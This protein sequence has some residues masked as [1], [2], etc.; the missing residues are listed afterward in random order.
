MQSLCRSQSQRLLAGLPMMQGI[1]TSSTMDESIARAEQNQRRR[2]P[3]QRLEK[4][5]RFAETEATT[6][7]IE[8]IMDMGKEAVDA[9]FFTPEMLQSFQTKAEKVAC[10]VF[11]K[12]K[13]KM[14]GKCYSFD[15]WEAYCACH[16]EKPVPEKIE[17]RLR[18]WVQKKGVR[19]GLERWSVP[20]LEATL[21]KVQKQALR[22]VLKMQ[23]S[24]RDP[25]IIAQIYGQLSRSDAQ[26]GV[27]MAKADEAVV[28]DDNGLGDQWPK[29]PTNQVDLTGRFSNQ[30]ETD[31]QDKKDID[32]HRT[33]MQPESTSTRKSSSISPTTRRPKL[34]KSNSV[35][36]SPTK[37][38]TS[39]PSSSPKSR[40]RLVRSSSAR[41]STKSLNN[42]ME[43][44]MFA[45]SLQEGDSTGST[46]PSG[47]GDPVS[48]RS[49]KLMVQ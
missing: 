11:A 27:L 24:R 14:D 44:V 43:Q 37:S 3:R 42:T 45:M 38:L 26:F 32:A 29:K 36:L 34:L 13:N 7:E 9:T 20:A 30:D 41:V 2:R 40:P 5:V 23:K 16:D 4:T 10:E 1:K 47:Q 8:R 15:M 25:E 28:R 12:D 46:G 49:Q 18:Y 22:A 17:E 35:R 6:I 48:P 19:R 21:G 33:E 39:M 31:Q